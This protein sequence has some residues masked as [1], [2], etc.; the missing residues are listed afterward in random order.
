MRAISNA[1]LS[2][3]EV[4]DKDRW[5]HGPLE[6]MFLDFEKYPLTSH[7]ELV[8]LTTQWNRSYEGGFCRDG[9][10]V[11]RL[12]KVLP[13]LIAAKNPNIFIAGRDSG[14]SQLDVMLASVVPNSILKKHGLQKRR[15]NMWLLPCGHHLESSGY[16]HACRQAF[17]EYIW[18]KLQRSSR[19]R[20]NFFAK[21]SPLRLLAADSH[22]WASRLF[23][24][25]LDRYEEFEPTED[26]EASWR[27]L[28]EIRTE[29]EKSIPAT[30]LEHLEIR[31]PRMGG[32]L[33]DTDDDTECDAV[34]EEMLDGQG[35]MEPID[36]L[37]DL[38]HSHQ[39]QED[40]SPVYSWIK[41]DFERSFYS[42]RAKVKVVLV[43]T[44]DD[45]PAWAI[46]SCIGHDDVIFRDILACFD[47]REQKLLIAV[48]HGK[49]TTEIAKDLGLKGH[50]SISRKLARIKERVRR[51]LS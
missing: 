23:R 19:C 51:L 25:A 21:T 33:W 44:V 1:F 3:A 11:E 10:S 26:I 48:R 37:L 34:V 15:A 45:H 27:P 20:Y 49:T 39:T 28:N 31:R 43:E 42:K 41:E 16:G 8:W 6:F 24:I 40:F 22:Y 38:L 12:E 30:E 29:F 4:E 50:A 46:G 13:G 47:S 7:S 18:Q 9:E 17:E 35:L 36:P 5:N 32:E 14:F 2:Q